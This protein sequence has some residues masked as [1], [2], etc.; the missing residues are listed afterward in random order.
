MKKISETILF[1]GSGPVAADSLLWLANNFNIEAV[2]T[3]PKKEHH[4]GD[5]PVLDI[6]NKLKIKTH[7]AIDKL[8]LEEI[9]E[10][11][12]FESKLAILIDYGIIISQ[13]IIDYFPLGII[14][15]HFSILPEWRGADPITFAI[16]SGQQETGVSLMK[17]TT[18][19]DEGPL[20][21][22]QTIPLDNTETTPILTEKLI[23]L[24]NKL[25]I[26]TIPNYLNNK[27]IPQDQKITK[28]NISYSRK[29]TK[30]DGKLNF[31]LPAE[32]LE[33]QIRAY[34]NWPKSKTIINNIP[35]AITKVKII[36][37]SGE[38]GIF[39][40]FNNQLA[41]YCYEKALLIE[42]LIPDNKK[43]MTSTAFMAGHKI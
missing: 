30:N 29:I 43:R 8:S 32:Q 10:T 17:L 42:E 40:R 4:I 38:P 16:L 23:N 11:N 25:I 35:V 33:R 19:M 28:K 15:S 24:S 1:F 31:N 21:N 13:K 7:Q 12:H 39:F 37:Q 18:K 36:N 6:T 5:V 14:N 27:I 22:W 34:I 20:L 26:K 41:V 3:K 2:I 9:F